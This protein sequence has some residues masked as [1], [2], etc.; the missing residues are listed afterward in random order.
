M[1]LDVLATRGAGGAALAAI[2]VMG[3]ATAKLSALVEF[4]HAESVLPTRY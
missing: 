2:I 3:L 1:A 4:R